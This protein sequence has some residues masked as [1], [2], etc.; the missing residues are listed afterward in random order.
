M[1]QLRPVALQEQS[2]GLSGDLMGTW[3]K[4]GKK[5]RSTGDRTWRRIRDAV[6]QR[7]NYTC[8]VRSPVCIIDA[9]VC[10]HTIPGV[11]LIE[12]LQAECE[13]CSVGH[14]QERLAAEKAQ[15]ETF[16][17]PSWL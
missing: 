2:R 10:G 14:W 6:L 13:P 16:E 4:D 15:A 8:Q 7:D 3:S 5:T 1:R 12:T 11:D 9:T 17:P